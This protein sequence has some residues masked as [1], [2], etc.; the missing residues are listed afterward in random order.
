MKALLGKDI[1]I[2]KVREIEKDVAEVTV[3][4]TPLGITDT[5]IMNIKTQEV[6]VNA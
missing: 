4:I 6:L 1:V 5:M 3:Y 2:L